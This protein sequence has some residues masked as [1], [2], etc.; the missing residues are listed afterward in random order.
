MAELTQ[1]ERLQPS[2]LDRL[3]DNDPEKKRESRDKRV[4]SLQKL[5][6]A[7]RRDLTWLL[8]CGNLE[9]TDDLDDYPEVGKSVINFGVPDLA[10][11]TVSTI[12]RNEVERMLRSAVLAFEPR[13]LPET[14]KVKLDRDHEEMN[15][16]AV[17]FLIEGELW[18]Q[19][20]PLQ[21]FLKT[22]LDLETGA[23]DVSDT[24]G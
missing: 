12:N 9:S 15:R 10:G 23:I 18:A 8:N 14:L 24:N 22:A 16:N 21:M 6:E 4:L 19:P 11:S 20:V 7:V 2:L 3:T 13:I 17:V 1:N 5:R